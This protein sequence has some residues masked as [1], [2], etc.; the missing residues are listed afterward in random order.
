MTIN[1]FSNEFDTLIQS[2]IQK[3]DFGN[4]T[5]LAFDEYEKSVFLTKAQEEIVLNI[6]KGIGEYDSFESSEESRRLL[7]SLVE[8]IE[9]EPSSEM[10][11]G[12]SNNSYFFRLPDNLMFI[13]YESVLF[14]CNNAAC[15][16][17][18]YTQV[19]PV[20]QDTVIRTM[21]NPF[22]RSSDTRVLRL[23]SRDSVIELISEHDIKNYLIKYIKI[24]TPI[25]LV[26]LPD[27][28]SINKVTSITECQLNPS[29]HRRI[30]DRAVLLALASKNIHK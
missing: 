18:N 21:E 19:I 13:T 25:V 9:L 26:E 27:D 3:V 16:K 30:L 14:K 12:I 23:D 10:N 28:L 29:L 22:R 1:E 2:Y 17:N 15:S 20:S 6:Y 7:N 8:T 11:K 4:I 5:P 24:P